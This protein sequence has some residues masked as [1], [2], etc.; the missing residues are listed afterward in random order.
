MNS[1]VSPR[2]T[3]CAPV[4][5]LAAAATAGLPGV[6]MGCAKV[7]GAS[8]GVNDAIA[9]G[10]G[11]VTVGLP[12]A[13]RSSLVPEPLHRTH[14]RGEVGGIERGQRAQAQRRQADGGDLAPAHD[15]RKLLD[16]I[17]VG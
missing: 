15:H 16:V 9:L 13:C 17:D 7:V 2:T 8:R 11:A 12:R 6:V 10:L 1:F 14:A 4:A 3:T 5:I